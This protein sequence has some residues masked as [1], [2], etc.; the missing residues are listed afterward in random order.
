MAASISVHM[1]VL[2]SQYQLKQQLKTKKS[3]ESTVSLF[4]ILDRDNN[5]EVYLQKSWRPGYAPYDNCCA[6]SL[7]CNALSMDI[8]TFSC[9][10]CVSCPEFYWWCQSDLGKHH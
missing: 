6:L 7:Q 10:R 3:K 9:V 8:Y 1:A 4:K 2:I 5:G